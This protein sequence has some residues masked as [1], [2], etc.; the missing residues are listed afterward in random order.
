[1]ID[2]VACFTDD[3]ALRQRHMRQMRGQGLEIPARQFGK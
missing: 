3:L 2:L 1:M